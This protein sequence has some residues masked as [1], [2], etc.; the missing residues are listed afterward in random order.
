MLTDQAVMIATRL[1]ALNQ[2]YCVMLIGLPGTGKT[3]FRNLLLKA[4][5]PDTP[6]VVSSD[7]L[8]HRRAWVDGVTYHDAFHSHGDR[9]VKYAEAI[10]RSAYAKHKNVLIDQTNPTRKSRARKLVQ[11]TAH[12]KTIGL[13]FTAPDATVRQRLINRGVYGADYRVH[14]RL[15]QIMQVPIAAEFDELFEITSE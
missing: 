4:L 12:Y 6:V 5:S 13:Y 9:A 14:A 2:P 10:M 1:R 7:D 3:T 15:A 8:L 11:A